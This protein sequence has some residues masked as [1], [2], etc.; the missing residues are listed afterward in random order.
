MFILLLILFINPLQA[1]TAP[2]SLEKGIK[3]FLKE[4]TLEECKKNLPECEK[5][6]ELTLKKETK[7]LAI[8]FKA[9]AVFGTVYELAELCALGDKLTCDLSSAI[10][11][12]SKDDCH[13]FSQEKK[14]L[15]S[16][17]R[18]TRL[19]QCEKI[20]D[21]FLASICSKNL[22]PACR[23]DMVCLI[24]WSYFFRED[25]ERLK[26][27]SPTII[28][29]FNF[30]FNDSK[31][32][33]LDRMDIHLPKKIIQL[34]I[35]GA[36]GFPAPGRINDFSVVGKD[37]SKDAVVKTKPTFKPLTILK[38]AF[39]PNMR[40]L[41]QPWTK[42][43]G[44]TVVDWDG[45]GFLDVFTVDGDNLL[46]FENIKGSEFRKHSIS[47][48]SF[49]LKGLLIDI[50]VVDIDNN[51]TPA[52]LVQS[53]PKTLYVLRWL[54]EKSSFS[55]EMITLPNF[56][57]THAYVKSKSGLRI[58]FPGWNGIGSAP[59]S[60]AA[61][62]IA[63]INNKEWSFEK[64]TTSEAPS[65]GVSVIERTLGHSTVVINR[66]LE[67]GTDFYDVVG[68]SLIKIPD[69]GKMNYFS[70]SA[71]LL[72]T[73]K[74][75]E[76]WF[77]SGLGFS[78][79]TATGKRKGQQKPKNIEECKKNWKEE[80]KE[81]CVLRLGRNITRTWPSLCTL[82]KNPDMTKACL[83]Q[84]EIP[85]IREV[86]MPNQF[87]FTPQI[88][89]N[90][91]APIIDEAASKLASELGQIWHL[92]PLK[93][94]SMEGFLVSES[95]A[96]ATKLRRLWWLGLT[97]TGMQKTELTNSLGLSEPYDATQFALGDFDKDDQ[98]DMV[99]KSG[100]DM[101]FLKGDTGGNSSLTQNLQSGH[102]SRT[103]IKIPTNKKE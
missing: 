24:A 103:L 90:L 91:S 43:E 22:L 92:S 75:E 39:A 62:Y 1:Q 78:K 51:G 95:M 50:S 61:D 30:D 74:N 32:L 10:L 59:N 76:L 102:Q 58:I 25:A 20:T 35:V 4:A 23:S 63:R 72:T 98:L 5:L 83:V 33:F 85:G 79:S 86:K 55:S 13:N 99:F 70:H 14:L 37:K 8:R 21:P 53:Y 3:Y 88:F 9:A 44:L 48:T 17:V 94:P 71:A 29:V 49:G 16:D 45:D 68:D 42:G 18:N 84:A 56:S 11:N 82:Y 34:D 100:K 41:I 19:N 2:D 46:L 57:R 67:G 97:K 27:S 77:T 28:K 80:E 81:F 40:Q 7:N 26:L 31:K 64:L 6:Y 96:D 60:F 101:V 54:K 47:L 69:T 87:K 89:R 73:S 38:G 52:I 93:S 36:P 15:C 65:L 66:D 12:D